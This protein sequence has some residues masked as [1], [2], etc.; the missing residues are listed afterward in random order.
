MMVDGWHA[1]AVRVRIYT[2]PAQ[3][4]ARRRPAR[5]AMDRDRDSKLL[6]NALVMVSDEMHGTVSCGR[7][8][9]FQGFSVCTPAARLLPAGVL[10]CW[11]RRNHEL[12]VVFRGLGCQGLLRFSSRACSRGRSGQPRRYNYPGRFSSFPSHE[13]R[14]F[15]SIAGGQLQQI[16]PGQPVAIT[17]PG[18]RHSGIASLR[19]GL[20]RRGRCTYASHVCVEL[21]IA[22]STYSLVRTDCSFGSNFAT[23]PSMFQKQPTLYLVFRESVGVSLVLHIT[24]V[25]CWMMRSNS[26]L[27]VWSCPLSVSALA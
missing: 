1:N 8:G 24:A 9:G 22:S 21:W 14:P 26:S 27:F 15:H 12:P 18:L 16:V 6:R 23:Q 4:P 3:R 19:I 2:T 20:R 11:S 13:T 5:E 25:L 7:R 10:W 17:G